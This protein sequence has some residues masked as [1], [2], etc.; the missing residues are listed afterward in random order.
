MAQRSWEDLPANDKRFLNALNS[1]T[2]IVGDDTLRYDELP[3]RL[4]RILRTVDRNTLFSIIIESFYLLLDAR[5]MERIK[6]IRR[7][8]TNGARA[9]KVARGDK[10]ARSRA[11]K[12]K[13][14]P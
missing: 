4:E 9:C 7:S 5:E 11:P 12:R 2:E 10:A 3:D 6:N 14:E 8:R 1:I 13:E